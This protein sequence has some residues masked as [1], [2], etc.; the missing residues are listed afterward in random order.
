VVTPCSCARED[1]DDSEDTAYEFYREW[2]DALSA[3]RITSEGD[4][5]S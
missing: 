2:F 5:S 3:L 4:E 1:F